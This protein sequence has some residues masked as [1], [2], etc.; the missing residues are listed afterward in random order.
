MLSPHLLRLF[1]LLI[2]A[3]FFVSCR[4]EENSTLKVRPGPEG[5]AAALFEAVRQAGEAGAPRVIELAPGTYRLRQ[6][7]VL[8]PEHRGLVIRGAG[9]G[10][11]PLLTSGVPLAWRPLTAPPAGLPKASQPVVMEADI[12]EGVP[13]PNR[14][15]GPDGA[16][17]L[18]AG[19]EFK[20]VI[21]D[22]DPRMSDTVLYAPPGV[23]RDWANPEDLLLSVTPRFQWVHNILRVADADPGAGTI[24]TAVPCSYPLVRRSQ[25]DRSGIRIL[26]TAEF[27]DE[28]GEWIVDSGAGRIYLIPPKG[29]DL[30]SVVVPALH[31]L[32]RI[33][34]ALDAPAADIVL[35]GLEL[36]H[37]R[38]HEWGPDER[39]VQ[40]DWESFDTGNAVVRLR[41]TENCT[42]RDCLIADGGSTGLR[43]D[44]RAV[45]NTI[46]N[47]EVSGMGGNGI[48]LGGLFY[49][50]RDVNRENL[51]LNNHV[52]AIGTFKRDGVGIL[53]TQSGA[54][55]IA[56][57]LVHD[58]GY[59][60]IVLSGFFNLSFDIG[61]DAG[62]GSVDRWP[63]RRE[64]GRL[65]RPDFLEETGLEPVT[66]SWD[67]LEP[68]LYTRDNV[69]EY[70]E[71]F[72][73][74]LRCG[75]GNAVYARGAGPGNLIR[76]NFIHH[77]LGFRYYGGIRMDDGQYGARIEENVLYLNGYTG[78]TIKAVNQVVNNVIVDVPSADDPLNP[79]R[80]P[81]MG[82][83]EYFV[84]RPIHNLGQPE[85]G[86]SVIER[87]IF[88][89]TRDPEAMLLG[90]VQRVPKYFRAEQ[91]AAA[92]R[93]VAQ[94]L[95]PDR[96]RD[97]LFWIVDNPDRARAFVTPGNRA[98]D[99]RLA[100]PAGG[101]FRFPED[102]PA[103]AM[104]IAPL[105]VREMGIRPGDLAPDLR[106]RLPDPPSR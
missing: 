22:T 97:N 35:E 89:S 76:R 50:T 60:G 15:Y 69:V 68:Y 70:N 73:T 38:F 90:Y 54:N 100:D 66:Q 21:D 19:P 74:V 72:N 16:L 7:I 4:A 87:N 106:N 101:D 8:G 30:D 93:E 5:D 25:H 86:E 105:D 42:V 12:P 53:I 1:P 3:A 47:N 75:D 94:A 20:P 57:N 91:P 58:T 84:N 61:E 64:L 2:L 27:L 28:P 31:E 6:P 88:L 52:H 23:V 10:A 96:F 37:T 51:V 79:Y 59:S 56:H 44:L 18:A 29:M 49:D 26:N 98:A 62:T 63:D 32:V 9:G 81:D 102:S 41:N 14:L 103:A 39:T 24:T 36:R 48:F 17:S 99:P 55:R 92:A 104:G 67:R 34:G 82:H 11:R 43:L 78:I 71:L 85:M 95:G 80:L 65:L 83:L 33:E 77:N 40:H 46:A 45:G 13:L